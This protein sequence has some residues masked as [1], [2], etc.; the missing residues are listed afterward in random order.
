MTLVIVIGSEV[1]DF[2]SVYITCWPMDRSTEQYEKLISKYNVPAPRYTSYPSYPFWDQD[3]P[4]QNR[5]LTALRTKFP[6]TN[7]ETGISLYVHLPFC[8]SLCTYCGCNTRITKN[9]EVEPKYLDSVLREREIY[10]DAFPDRPII[11]E[12]HLGGGTPTF[13]RPAHLEYLVDAL[14]I[15]CERHSDFEFGFECH[16]NNTTPEHLR[17]LSE[18]GFTRISIGVQDFDPKVQKAINRGQSFERVKQVTDQARE[19]GY[20]SINFDLIY[21]LPFQTPQSIQ[22]TF[23][24]VSQLKPDRIA[25][26]SYAHVPWKRPGQRGYSENDLPQGKAKR[27]LYEQGRDLILGG[28]Y[29]EIGMDHFALPGD[30]L[31]KAWKHK[32]LHRNFM[33]YTPVRTDLPTDYHGR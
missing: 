7:R 27:N 10:L 4:D 17:T 28:G 21:G 22:Y 15:K 26:Y 25:F 2:C 1:Y 29:Q 23:D 9:H 6:E 13:F 19:L 32:T 30:D 3:S 24:R 11:R 8:E 31:Y 20:K 5:W 33:G 18:L 16:P 14:L 12:L